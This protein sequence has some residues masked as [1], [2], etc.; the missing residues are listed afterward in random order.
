MS[1]GKKHK[2]GSTFG[3][4]VKHSLHG[5]SNF[6][7]KALSVAELLQPEFLPELAIGKEVLKEV[8]R[9]TK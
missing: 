1:F 3:M 9:L 4:G 6:G 2:H 5:V 8:G 7:V